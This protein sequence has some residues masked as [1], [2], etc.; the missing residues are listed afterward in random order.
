VPDRCEEE[1]LITMIP[2]ENIHDL[3]NEIKSVIEGVKAT[4]SD[5]KYEL[6]LINVREGCLMSPQH[7][8][9]QEIKGIVKEVIGRELPFIG[10]LSSTD[11]NYQVNDGKMPCF[12]FGVGGPYSNVHK[13]DE[14]AAIDE[15]VEC[16]KIVALVVMRKLGV[17]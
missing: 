5:L 7:P 13:Q 3:Q 14:S 8:Y 11:I 15:I 12:N 2:G 9:I 4:D 1:V 16:A 6:E 10:T 17:Q